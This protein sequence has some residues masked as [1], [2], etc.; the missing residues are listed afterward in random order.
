MTT[1]KARLSTWRRMTV[2]A[3]TALWVCNAIARGADR[4]EYGSPHDP[5]EPTVTREESALL[6]TAMRVAG[7]NVTQAIRMLQTKEL[8]EASP[9]NSLN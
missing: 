9:A 5:F 6:N 8:P 4:H 3:F 2:L 7:T 1:Q